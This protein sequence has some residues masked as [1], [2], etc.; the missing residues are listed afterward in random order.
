MN[1]IVPM[2]IMT[3]ERTTPDR[4]T[5]PRILFIELGSFRFTVSPSDSIVP[6]SRS[7]SQ[8]SDDH[9]YGGGC[10]D[11][12]E[13]LSD[14]RVLGLY[15]DACSEGCSD[16]DAQSDWRGYQR[17]DVSP[18]EIDS[19]ARGRGDSDH[20]VGGCCGDFHRKFHREIHGENLESSA[21]YSEEPGDQAGYEHARETLSRVCGIVLDL[22]TIALY[23]VASEVQFLCESLEL[24][25]WGIFFA[26]LAYER[27]EGDD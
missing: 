17:V 6:A 26:D 1:S 10:Q 11:E 18:R 25:W 8:C 24:L 9:F 16:E 5:I 27:Y 15:Q 4:S 14:H 7:E 21:S 13:D 22:S 2:A 20:E 19:R 12:C 3:P 23:V